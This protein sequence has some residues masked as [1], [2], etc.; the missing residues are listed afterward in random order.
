MHRNGRGGEGSQEEHLQQ[1]L[2]HLLTVGGWLAGTL[3]VYSFG[4]IETENW[5][6]M[7]KMGECC[8]ALDG[9]E[10]NSLRTVGG[11]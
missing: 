3:S 5:H 1:L 4:I 2:Q 10:G 11:I 7:A 6:V 8:A 9:T